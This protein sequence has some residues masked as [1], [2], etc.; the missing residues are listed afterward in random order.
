MTTL[1][2]VDD[3]ARQL[4]VTVRYVRRLIAERRVPFIKCGH[5]IRFDPVQIE[6]WIQQSRVEQARPLA[7]ATVTS[8]RG[9]GAPASRPTVGAARRTTKS[10]VR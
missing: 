2:T 8:F 5:Y 1:W 9:H 7:T 10:S 3:L 6:E 4:G